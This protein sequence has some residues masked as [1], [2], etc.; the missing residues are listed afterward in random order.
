MLF[1]IMPGKE[2]A[3]MNIFPAHISLDESGKKSIQSVAE[4]CQNTADR[5][6]L[7]L[8]DVGFGKTA[9]LVG[10]MHDFG[11][12]TEKFRQYIS[13]A[14]D[15]K[16]VT[17]GSVNHTFA[18]S[19]YILDNYH[20]NTV[21]SIKDIT[22][23]IIAF[24]IGSHHGI[25]DIAGEDAT[26]NGF[27]HRQTKEDIDYE[28]ARCNFLQNCISE[29]EIQKLFSSACEEIARFTQKIN[30]LCQKEREVGQSEMY[31]YYNFLCRLILSAAVEGDSHDTACFMS[32]D[33][34]TAYK[35]DIDWK[36]LSNTLEK[37]LATL[38]NSTPLS[39]IRCSISKACA[40][41]A[42]KKKGIYRLNVPT[43]GG[44]TL[45]SLRYALY[46]AQRY[47]KKRIIFTMPLLSIIEQ[48]AAVIKDFLADA[49]DIVLEHHSNVLTPEEGEA[50]DK[51][52]LL[53]EN[54]NA[55][56]IVTTLV[57]L[58]YT[59]FKDKMGSVRRFHSLC[60]S[61]LVID[62]VQ[63]VPFKMLSLFNLACNF[64]TEICDCTLIF[65]S[66][67]QPCFEKACHPIA[68][69]PT[70][71]IRIPTE[72]LK[73][74]DRVKIINNGLMNIEQLVTFA[75]E[76]L[77]VKRTVLLI[78]NTKREAKEIFA[79][80]SEA[81][82]SDTASFYLSASLCTK[83]R[84]N[85]VKALREAL[86]QK[87]PV[88]CV[89]TQVIEAGVDISFDCVIRLCAGMDSIIQAAGRCNRN[90]ESNLLSP[91]YIVELSSE[92]L[93]HLPEIAAGKN[94]CR[95]LLA[96]YEQSPKSFHYNLMSDEAIGFFY[97]KLFFNMK[98]RY[99]D[100][101]K[102]D[103]EIFLYDL[104]ADNPDNSEKWRGKYFLQAAL[105]TGGKE[106]EIFE[107]DTVDVIVPYKK[108]REIIAE[109]CSNK[110]KYSPEY[111]GECLKTVKGYTVSLFRYQKENLQ[112]KGG[113]INI[114]NG[115]LYILEQS[116]YDDIFGITEEPKTS[117]EFI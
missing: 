11:K 24:S 101:Y 1:A 74:F 36:A 53:L 45:S 9:Y 81:L 14:A 80:I 39:E 66:A 33:Q 90:G 37:K 61:I 38:D 46:H 3:V 25:F 44:K 26:Q 65:C 86:E 10:I 57:Q 34:H 87:Q 20:H 51:R 94:A 5:A 47:H 4:H 67:T 76:Q 115:N 54:W 85:V 96:E 73:A 93:S 104:F 17:R 60:G 16:N 77:T 18:G 59:I 99:Q 8:K 103:K 102:K 13:D 88:I 31:F 116:Y 111:L 21:Q 6:E 117:A 95:E 19:R 50:L 48:N 112:Q 82:S 79:G 23:E 32:L 30:K 56:I 49:G 2:K 27:L 83:H 75:K 62:E 106:F 107:N 89:S 12:Y 71:L 109:I 29:E 42:E 98:K 91:V 35:N 40:S 68:P 55:P 92:Q 84:Q 114:N 52:E 41:A 108:G 28:E 97:R 69:P 70:D 64:L 43:G 15:G 7:L 63:T 58:L 78:C 105:K 110:A 100:F 72:A 22:A 113:L